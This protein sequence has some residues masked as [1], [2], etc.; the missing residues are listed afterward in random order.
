[1]SLSL[2]GFGVTRLATVVANNAVRTEPD[3]QSLLHL[4][5][6]CV[7]QYSKGDDNKLESL[8]IELQTLVERISNPRTSNLC[9]ALSFAVLLLSRSLMATDLVSQS[10]AKSR[11]AVLACY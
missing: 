1:M 4:A 8:P 6:E 5:V 7:A 3:V 10:E 2:S 9:V 11:P